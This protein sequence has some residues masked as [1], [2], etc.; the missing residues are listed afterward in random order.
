[1]T[2]FAVLALT[3]LIAPAVSG[4]NPSHSTNSLRAQDAAIVK[5]SRDA[6]LGLYSLD[7]KYAAA[8]ARVA[9]L[10]H[11]AASLREQRAILRHQLTVARQGLRI[12]QQRLA[13]RLRALY[14]QGNVEP[15]DVVLGASNLDEALTNL[16]NL[17]RVSGQGEDV[18]REFKSARTATIDLSRGLARREA[19]LAAETRAAEAAAASL[20]QTLAARHAYIA[21]LASRRRMTEQRI[22]T[23]VAQAQAASTRSTTLARPAVQPVSYTTTSAPA[24]TGGRTITVS[25]TG[26]SLPGHTASG[27]AVGW[28][29]VAVD[30]SVIPLGTHITIPGYGEAVAADTGG[31]VVGSTIDLW[32]PTIAQANAWGRRVVTIVV[33]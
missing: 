33:H 15:I 5:K 1:L 26:Y 4:A 25:A 3:V 6:V 11:A 23:L 10:H 31:A 9:S 2:S 19:A 22:S 18:L 27:L 12:S 17:Q 29:V 13:V 20:E 28:G 24:P 16:D 14:E 7:Q 32:F 30:P 21:S 8:Q